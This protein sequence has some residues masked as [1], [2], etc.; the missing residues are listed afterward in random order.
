MTFYNKLEFNNQ[1]IMLTWFICYSCL[2]ILQKIISSK[3]TKFD[4]ILYTSS[5]IFIFCIISY[6]LNIDYNIVAILSVSIIYL[7]FKFKTHN[8]IYASFII[9]LLS[10]LIFFNF[11]TILCIP[12]LALY[13]PN[14]VCK[15]KLKYIF[16]YIYPLHLLVL[17]ILNYLY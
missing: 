5:T 8:Y 7:M 3:Y 13:K 2:Y 12:L 17:L 6:I 14:K 15:Y 11:G 9:F 1:N 10:V 4:T 16:Y